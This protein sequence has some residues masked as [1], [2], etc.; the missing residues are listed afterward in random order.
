[1]DKNLNHFREE[2]DEHISTT[3]FFT[4]D[5]KRAVRRK[6]RELEGSKRKQN[7]LFPLMMSFAAVAVFFFLIG[8]YMGDQLGLLSKENFVTQQNE[9]ITNPK[10]EDGIKFDPRTLELGTQL[11]SF[12]VKSV[13][14]S[15]RYFPASPFEAVFTGYE[16]LSGMF[17]YIEESEELLFYPDEDEVQK[18]PAPEGAGRIPVISIS[19]FAEN[20][21]E[22]IELLEINPGKKVL[23][24]VTFTWYRMDF[25]ST[26]EQVDSA[27]IVAVNGTELS[28]KE[29]G[30]TGVMDE[31]PLE[32]A[33]ISN[34]LSPIYEKFYLTGND[35]VLK[36]LKPEDIFL[37]FLQA[38]E[39]NHTVTMY[40]LMDDENTK[41]PSYQKF[42]DN[43]YEKEVKTLQIEFEKIKANIGNLE[44]KINNDHASIGVKGDTPYSLKKDKAGIWK[45]EYFF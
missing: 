8:G 26:G 36:G 4:E 2:I 37:M 21:D 10:E 16:T 6:I 44:I 34:H 41:I 19:N 17:H 22:V 45:L 11:G 15:A 31:V 33:V 5:D 38:F 43:V 29:K 20:K 27:D 18:L 14:P 24:N 9:P 3:A 1:M 7:R 42:V 39:F 28:L 13:S 32:Y 40:E 25:R 23:G 12:L 35:N 30:N